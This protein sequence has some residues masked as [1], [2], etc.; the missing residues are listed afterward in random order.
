MRKGCKDGQLSLL[1]PALRRPPI[2]SVL[3]SSRC[4]SCL[5]KI[6]VF[7]EQFERIQDWFEGARAKEIQERWWLSS[8]KVFRRNNCG[9]GS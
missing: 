8:V 4:T 6:I 3:P 7:E 2:W 1:P 9:G 5:M